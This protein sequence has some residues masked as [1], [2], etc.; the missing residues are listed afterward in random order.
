MSLEEGIQGIQRG[1]FAFHVEPGCGYK[2][3]QDTFEEA[4]K[5]GFEEL[6]FLNVFDPH[7]I[8]QRDSPFLELFRVGYITFF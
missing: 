6:D 4:E 7:H 1:Y 8:I 3:I 2:L 5:C